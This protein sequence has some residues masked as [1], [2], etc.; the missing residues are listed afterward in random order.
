MASY[1]LTAIPLS[2]RKTRW[3]MAKRGGAR[4]AGVVEVC[5]LRGLVSEAP[6]R[7]LA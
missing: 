5:G 3:A 4:I 2:L 6:G 7:M 1:W